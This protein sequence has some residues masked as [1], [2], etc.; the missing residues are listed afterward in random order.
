MNQRPKNQVIDKMN[1]APK[2]KPETA[3]RITANVIRVCKLTQHCVAYRI[4]NAAVYDAK[5][6][7][8]RA[9]N[10]EKGL[11]DII[12]VY[13]G[14]FIGIEVKA[15]KDRLSIWQLHRREEIIQADGIYFECRSTDDFLAFWENLKNGVL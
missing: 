9:G 10:I 6:K 3:N 2:P 7:A 15:G 12:A 13:K 4:N 5:A 1:A 14:R 11:P 8:Y